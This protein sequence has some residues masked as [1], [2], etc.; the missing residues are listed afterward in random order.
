MANKEYV[1]GGFTFY[2][3]AD[4]KEAENELKGVQ[5]MK[6]RIDYTNLE[7]ALASYNMMNNKKLFK[8]PIGYCFLNSLRDNIINKGI[9]D[10]DI[11]PVNIVITSGV[12][13]VREESKLVSKYKNRFVNVMILNVL[14]I[15]MIVVFAVIANNSENINII[16]YKNR[17]DA[18]YASMEDS[19]SQW[20]REL[21]EKEIEL[22]KLEKELNSR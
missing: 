14:L 21:K 7:S 22:D 20:S 10:T 15:I 6:S 3:E 12:K 8:T 11:S 16:N 2:D 9:N 18:Q 17:I 4:A 1:V 19:L 5:Y 13:T